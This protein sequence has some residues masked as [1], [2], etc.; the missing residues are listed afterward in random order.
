M[1]WLSVP[2]LTAR[3]NEDD[4]DKKEKEQPTAGGQLEA[5]LAAIN[6]VPAYVNRAST[7][8]ILCPVVAHHEL[9]EDCEYSSWLARGWCR[10]ESCVAYLVGMNELLMVQS[11]EHIV[12][13]SAESVA[14]GHPVG[15]GNFAC[16]RQNHMVEVDGKQTPIPCDRTKVSPVLEKLFA[17]RLQTLGLQDD[18]SDYRFL[19]AHDQL[20]FMNLTCETPRPQYNTWEDFCFAF[21]LDPSDHR[22]KCGGKYNWCPLVW[23][24]LSCNLPITRYLIKEVGVGDDVNARL[25]VKKGV[26][27]VG[28]GMTLMH[29]ICKIGLDGSC[30]PDIF[31]LLLEGK[32]DPYCF[33]ERNPGEKFQDPL[34][35]AI[36]F[37]NPEIAKHYLKRVKPNFLNPSDGFGGRNESLVVG[38]N[39]QLSLVKAFHEAGCTFKSRNNFGFSPL[40]LFCIAPK[41]VQHTYDLEVLDYLK[42]NNLLGDINGPQFN[43]SKGATPPVKKSG[44]VIYNLLYYLCKAGFLKNNNLF[45]GIYKIAGGTC[46]HAAVFRDKPI[47]VTWLLRNTAD[48]NIRTRRGQT[49]LELATEFHHTRCM[50]VRSRATIFH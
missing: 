24:V 7:I 16:C 13:H 27:V 2:Q 29:T 25:K 4:I 10:L 36:V 8:L 42:D 37:V 46:I 34:A 18:W 1:D 41:E 20:F 45:Q 6:S 14:F 17:K 31:D 11:T 3:Y 21:K 35:V 12:L 43:F 15:N 32:A 50:A 39:G 5:M 26:Q 33:T 23:A 30:A 47:V 40:G 44:K 38:V 48:P 49:A 22:K 19:L 28:S 9:E